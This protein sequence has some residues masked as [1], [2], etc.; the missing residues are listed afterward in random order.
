MILLKMDI[1]YLCYNIYMDV[2]NEIEILE[3]DVKDCNEKCQRVNCSAVYDAIM[4]SLKLLYDLIFFCCKRKI[5]LKP[6]KTFFS[7]N[8]Y[9]VS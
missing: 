1:S 5:N 4:S 2:V 7:N 6:L 9:Y 3:T 8:I